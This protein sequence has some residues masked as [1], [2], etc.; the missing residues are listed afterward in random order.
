[1]YGGGAPISL[2]EIGAFRDV[3]YI[4]SPDIGKFSGAGAMADAA[5]QAEWH[6]SGNTARH[7]QNRFFDVYYALYIGRHALGAVSVEGIGDVQSVLV[8]PTPQVGDELGRIGWVGWLTWL[9][10]AILND[11]WLQRLEFALKLEG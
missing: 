10:Y 3:R 8:Q 7:A 9:A 2:H 1:M 11:M 6:T 4:A 5:K